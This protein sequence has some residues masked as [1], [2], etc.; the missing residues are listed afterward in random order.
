MTLSTWGRRLVG[1]LSTAVAAILM[2]GAFAVA[3]GFGDLQVGTVEA[4]A[5]TS[6]Q[7]ISVSATCGTAGGFTGTVTLDG[8]FTGTVQL[9]LFYH[10]PGGSQFVDSGLRANA[11]FTGGNTATYNFASFIFPG[12]NSYRIQVINAAGLGG[13]TT[14]SNSVPP[15]TGT[16]TTTTT[17]STTSTTSSTTTVTTTTG[18]TTTGTTTTGTTT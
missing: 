8:S 2:L 10:V 7:S 11:T 13:A 16:T 6:I 14:K 12:A 1:M 17:S 4:A 9:G 15:C 3:G 18:T 5:A